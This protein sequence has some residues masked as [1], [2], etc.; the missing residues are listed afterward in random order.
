MVQKV[1][2]VQQQSKLGTC[3]NWCVLSPCIPAFPPFTKLCLGSSYD[4]A[5]L[6][7]LVCSISQKNVSPG[8]APCQQIDKAPPASIF[9]SLTWVGVSSVEMQKK[10]YVSIFV[11]SWAERRE[12]VAKQKQTL[13][14]ILNFNA[15]VEDNLCPARFTTAG[16]E[17]TLFPLIRKW[18]KR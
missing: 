2:Q 1:A 6:T 15:V 7:L 4:A 10:M 3:S 14:I 13:Q 16:N 9:L 12:R 11:F 17:P 18:A 8:E 5:L